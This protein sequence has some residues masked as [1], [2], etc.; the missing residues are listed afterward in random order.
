MW[1]STTKWRNLAGEMWEVVMIIGR[2]RGGS[3]GGGDLN[4]LRVANIS[5]EFP[6][7][8]LGNCCTKNNIT[9]QPTSQI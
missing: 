8:H 4:D 6:N 7:K 1:G 9:D 2:G 3:D 5:R